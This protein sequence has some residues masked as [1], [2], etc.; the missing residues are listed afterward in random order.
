MPRVSSRLPYARRLRL[1]RAIARYRRSR[2]ARV[3]LVAG[4]VAAMLLSVAVVA[5]ASRSVDD[6]ARI[7]PL[8]NVP[9]RF[10]SSGSPLDPTLRGAMP[11]TDFAAEDL[12]IDKPAAPAAADQPDKVEQPPVEA[13]AAAEPVVV[14]V[15][16]GQ[17]M[18]AFNGRTVRAVAKRRM[19]VTAYCPCARCCGKHADGIT[20]SGYSVFTNSGRIVAADTRLLPFGTMLSIPGYA[21]TEVVPVLDTGKDIKG[22]RLDVFF[23]SHRKAREWGARWL[24]VTIYDYVD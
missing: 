24:T 14:D 15:E 1:R 19:L 23:A 8:F 4:S 3:T 6:P 16:D 21:R 17:T 13:V 10:E 11:L 9:V 18:I 7:K 2:R 5:I 12:P 22:N 20:A